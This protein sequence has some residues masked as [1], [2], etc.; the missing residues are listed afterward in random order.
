VIVESETFE[1]CSGPA[2][3]WLGPTGWRYLPSP[4]LAVHERGSQ[5]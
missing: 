3:G 4:P 1:G 2:V 5:G